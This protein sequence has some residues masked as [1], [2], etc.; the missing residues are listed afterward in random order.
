[1]VKFHQRAGIEEIASQGSTFPAFSDNF[2]GHRSGNLGKPSP[3]FLD[4]RRQRDV[5]K[6]PFDILD[7]FDSQTGS[8]AGRV[9]DDT[10]EYV[11]MLLQI[12]WLQRPQHAILVHSVNLN[13]HATIVQPKLKRR[14]SGCRVL[15]VEEMDSYDFDYSALLSL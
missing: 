11:L 4:T 7:V 1:M 12:Q 14:N 5:F 6:F 8:V 2:S 10:H 15:I 13:G 9:F 3:N